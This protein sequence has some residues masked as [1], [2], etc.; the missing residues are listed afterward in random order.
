ML[1]QVLGAGLRDKGEKREI[2]AAFGIA[3]LGFSPQLH[4]AR[5]VHL[6]EAGDVRRHTLRHHHVVGGDLAD[7]GPRLDAVARPRV[8]GRM[9]DRTGRSRE[10]GAR[11]RGSRGGRG[12][13]DV[14][15][16]VL[17][18]HA[19]RVTTAGDSRDIDAVLG[20]DFANKRRR[21][22]AEALLGGL[23]ATTVTGGR[24]A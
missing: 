13:F 19:A 12:S 1:A 9:F 6:E 7:L 22:G 18:G 10:S 15:Q 5:E 3:L 23:Y 2:H 21:L 14:A 17:F 20:S 16:D 4:H 24:T 11:S 8:H